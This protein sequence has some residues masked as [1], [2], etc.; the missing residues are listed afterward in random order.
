MN[1]SLVIAEEHE[2]LEEDVTEVRYRLLETVR[3][4][5]LSKLQQAGIWEQLCERHAMWYLHLAEQANAHLYGTQQAMWLHYL[6][7][8][9][10]NLNAALTRSLAVGH[11]HTVVTTGRCLAPFLDH[12]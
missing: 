8:E 7:L 9:T 5:A 2:G 6:E 1:A 12:T 10:A 4:Y 3:Q 11:L